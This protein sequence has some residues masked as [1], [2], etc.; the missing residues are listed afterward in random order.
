MIIRCCRCFDG[1]RMTIPAMNRRL[2]S[3]ELF[4]RCTVKIQFLSMSNDIENTKEDPSDRHPIEV[5][6][7]NLGEEGESECLAESRVLTSVRYLILSPSSLGMIA[8]EIEKATPPMKITTDEKS[9]GDSLSVVWSLN[10]LSTASTYLTH[11][12]YWASC[13]HLSSHHWS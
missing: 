12:V 5:G 6:E 9:E 1:G 4:R 13:T 3:I 11:R 2:I 8:C 10:Q 7:I